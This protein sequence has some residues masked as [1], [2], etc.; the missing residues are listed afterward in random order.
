MNTTLLTAELGTTSS[1][2]MYTTDDEKI[3][4]NKRNEV[5]GTTLVSTATTAVGQSMNAHGQKKIYEKYASAYVES[6]TDEE[7]ELALQKMDLLAIDE[8]T[9]QQTK[10]I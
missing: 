10:T 1:I 7:L 3:L 4:P 6:M 2:T 5:I 9:D 8:Q